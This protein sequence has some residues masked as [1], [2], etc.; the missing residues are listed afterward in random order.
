MN[1]YIIYDNSQKQ[2]ILN[3][4][5]YIPHSFLTA[6]NST[7]SGINLYASRMGAEN[8]MFILSGG[9]LLSVNNYLK[10]TQLAVLKNSAN[11]GIYNIKCQIHPS[12]F[13]EENLVK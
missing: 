7:V 9:K 6:N 12:G 4:F 10:D 11:V 1:N 5:A 3:T 13:S 2:T 8:S